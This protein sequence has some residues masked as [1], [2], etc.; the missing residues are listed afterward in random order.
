MAESTKQI[1]RKGRIY[2]IKLDE[3]EYR[4]FIWQAGSGFCGRVEDHPQAGLC[5]GRTVIAVQDQLSTA[6]KASL[7]T[8]AQSE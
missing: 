5:R 7:A 2:Y 1:V 6:L 8:D 3:Q 4:T